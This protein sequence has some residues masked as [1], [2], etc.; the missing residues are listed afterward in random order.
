MPRPSTAITFATNANYAGGPAVGTPT[1]VAPTSGLTQDGWRPGEK[2]GAQNFGYLLNNIGQWLTWLNANVWDGLITFS[3]LITFASGLVASPNQHITVSGTG[4][5]KHG[6]R[7]MEV[8]IQAPG[9][10]TLGPIAITLTSPNFAWIPI[11]GLPVGARIL[12]IHADVTDSATGPTKLT[13]LLR[14]SAGTDSAFSPPSAGTGA[15]QTISVT[16]LT[17]IV[18]AGNTYFIIVGFSTGTANCFIN[19]ARVDYDQP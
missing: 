10:S 13:C 15:A 4:L 14:P 11:H 1:K 16:G 9:Q 6:S 2:P 5:Y 8:P 19:A 3:D 12:A 18:A 17:T 7:T